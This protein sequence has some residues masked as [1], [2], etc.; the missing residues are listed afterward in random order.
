MKYGDL[1]P[2]TFKTR[3]GISLDDYVE[4]DMTPS[5]LRAKG[6]RSKRGWTGIVE[7]KVT[8]LENNHFVGLSGS[9]DNM[10]LPYS[11]II[12]KQKS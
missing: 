12:P 3:N 4:V 2:S 8:H 10:V 9:L 6:Y 1:P 11:L 5:V 7:F